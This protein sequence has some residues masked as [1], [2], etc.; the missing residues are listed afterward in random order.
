MKFLLEYM[1]V[2]INEYMQLLGENMVVIHIRANSVF[3]ERTKLIEVDYHFMRMK[4]Q[5]GTRGT[6]HVRSEDKLPNILTN[7]LG[8]ERYCFLVSE[9]G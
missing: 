5:N 9:L 6:K 4:L 7:S 3:H 1:N 2:N 8:G